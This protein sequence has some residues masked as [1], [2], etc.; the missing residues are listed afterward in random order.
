[1]VLLE[2]SLPVKNLST[3]KKSSVIYK[4]FQGKKLSY[5][6]TIYLVCI[7]SSATLQVTL[8]VILA[9]LQVTILT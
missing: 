7:E 2:T 1:M 6:Q 9:L 8:L 5:I 4:E 3:S